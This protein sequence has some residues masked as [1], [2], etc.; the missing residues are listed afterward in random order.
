MEINMKK[1]LLLTILLA[2][3][4]SACGGNAESAQP[5][6]I[7]TDQAYE[8]YQNGTFLLDV[9][10]QAE[11]DEAHAP[12]TTLIPLDELPNR[13]NELSKEELI[14]VICRSG[15]RSATARDLL[16]DAGFTQV[17]SMAGGLTEWASKGYPITSD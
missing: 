1:L 3:S 13:L 4:L 17:T 16:L 12:N 15:N 2:F 6:E 10:T 11:W 14:V 7:S 9:R 5:L 8:L